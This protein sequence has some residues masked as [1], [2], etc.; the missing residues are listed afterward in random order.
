MKCYAIE[1]TPLKLD[2]GAMFGNAPKELWKR[3]TTSDELNRIPLAARSLLLQTENGQNILFEAGDCAFFD[4]KL[5]KRYGIETSENHLILNL[6]ALGIT[7]NDI[8]IV[9]LSHLHFDHA[10]GIIPAYGQPQDRLLF[11][12]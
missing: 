9:V 11:P 6:A 12:C 10:C 3:W 8:D 4:P 7:E 2:G 1:N 5:K